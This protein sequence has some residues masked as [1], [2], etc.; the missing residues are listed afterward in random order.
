MFI[1]RIELVH[2]GIQILVL[3]VRPTGVVDENFSTERAS[4]LCAAAEIPPKYL[5]VL[6]HTHLERIQACI[7]RYETFTKT[8]IIYYGNYGC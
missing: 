5:F 4:A 3:L 2:H 8:I 1:Y 6:S 7:Q